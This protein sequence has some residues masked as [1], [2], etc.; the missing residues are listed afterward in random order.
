MVG[1]KI[2]ILCQW[3]PKQKPGGYPGINV[4]GLGWW[5]TLAELS[6]FAGG[7]KM[8]FIII[9]SVIFY[10]GIGSIIWGALPSEGSVLSLFL[11]SIFWPL[12]CNSLYFRPPSEQNCGT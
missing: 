9:L 1:G 3:K 12:F 6:L 10:L 5:N 4:I 2:A 8:I 7:S 11:F